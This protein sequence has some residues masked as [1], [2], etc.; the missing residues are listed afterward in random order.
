MGITLAVDKV[1]VCVHAHANTSMSK[2]K[3]KVSVG[4]HSPSLLHPFPETES[5]N[6][7][8][9]LIPWL[10]LGGYSGQQER[11][12]HSAEGKAVSNLVSLRSV[13]AGMMKK[14]LTQCFLWRP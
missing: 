8:E 5:L 13:R 4:N 2:K 6:Q 10:V 12:M 11:W 9:S 14:L 3:P 7:A 1:D